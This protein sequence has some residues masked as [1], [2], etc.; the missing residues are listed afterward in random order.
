MSSSPYLAVFV[1][2]IS[3]FSSRP[4]ALIP[5]T[6]T[7]LLNYRRNRLGTCRE[8]Y[9]FAPEIPNSPDQETRI[10]KLWRSSEGLPPIYRND[11]RL[12]CTRFLVNTERS[13]GDYSSHNPHGRVGAR[14]ARG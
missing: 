8:D 9:T 6:D 12:H 14:A 13:N 1:S 11:R 3:N 4:S 10:G 2:N 7:W 5:Y